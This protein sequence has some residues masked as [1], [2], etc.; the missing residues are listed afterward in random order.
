[1]LALALAVVMTV[2]VVST[3][4]STSI[5]STITPIVA[6]TASVTVI[7]G[8]SNTSPVALVA[9]SHFREKFAVDL[10]AKVC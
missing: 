5:N 8:L 1:M 10:V 2:V 9:A 3:T 4:T 7:F 6:S